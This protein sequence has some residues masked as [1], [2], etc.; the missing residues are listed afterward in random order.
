[1]ARVI[2]PN[3]VRP[4]G[5]GDG[6]TDLIRRVSRRKDSVFGVGN[7]ASPSQARVMT[8]AGMRGFRPEE[9]PG[10]APLGLADL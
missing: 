1:M 8:R 3:P 6:S 7:F 9:P 4:Y 5:G 10:R 2:S